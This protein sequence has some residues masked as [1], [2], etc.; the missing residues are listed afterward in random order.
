MDRRLPGWRLAEQRASSS[1]LEKATTLA[2]VESVL[3]DQRDPNSRA[4]DHWQDRPSLARNL[5]SVLP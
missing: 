4:D 5:L 1:R 3:A 2:K